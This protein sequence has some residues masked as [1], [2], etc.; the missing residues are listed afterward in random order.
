MKKGLTE[1]VFVLDRSGSMSGLESDTIGGFNSMIE[2]QKKQEGEAIVTSVLFDD[3]YELIH[4][5][6][7]ISMVRTITENEYFVR[8]CTALLDAIGKTI[9]KIGNVQKYLPEVERAEKVIFVITTDG[10]ENSSKEYSYEKLRHMIER[11]KTR[12][13]WE[14]IFLGANIDAVAEAKKFGID[15]DR[16][17]T[18]HND[19]EGVAM[20]YRVVSEAVCE[21][22]CAPKMADVGRGWKE[23]IEKDYKKRNRK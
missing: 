22:R 9:H 4:D 23:E 12:F 2:K 8:G 3:Q 16:A 21:M 10:L 20:N 17:V 6:F 15:E 5:R 19:S 14:F 1:L 11:Q 18:Y 7:P 13:G